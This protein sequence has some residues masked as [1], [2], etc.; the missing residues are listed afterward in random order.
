M[1]QSRRGRGCGRWGVVIGLTALIATLGGQTVTAQ[2]THT[3]RYGDTLSQIAASYGL[4]VQELVALNGIEDP[5]LIIAGE[6]LQLGS[7]RGVTDLSYAG[8]GDVAAND[9]WSDSESVEEYTAL[10]C[11][12][13]YVDPW[14]VQQLL[15]ETAEVYGWD[16]TLI[17]AQAWQ[18]SYWGQHQVSWVGA[19]GVMQ[20]MPSTADGMNDWYFERDRDTWGSVADNIEAGV[21]YLTVL[22]EVTGS[23]ELAL[24]S[25]YQGW[26]SV[27]RDGFFPDTHEYVDR[28]FTF[29]VM[30]Q[31]GELP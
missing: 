22:Y 9:E 8:S 1:Y 31:N 11:C 12:P 27:Q 19:V 4:T 30:F 16:P 20:V 15:I 3:I 14:T 23:V 24:A 7:S 18:E 21:A 25:Y 28:I 17:M 5:D 26:A 10:R 13:D 29:Q 2:D 6:I